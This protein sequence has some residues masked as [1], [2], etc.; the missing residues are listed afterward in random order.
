M[1]FFLGGDISVGRRHRASKVDEQG[2]CRVFGGRCPG[3]VLAEREDDRLAI[4][5]QCR[6]AESDVRL[7]PETQ[8]TLRQVNEL[9][10]HPVRETVISPG[11]EVRTRRLAA[12]DAANHPSAAT[13]RVLEQIEIGEDFLGID[14][15]VP[16]F[17]PS[18][19]PL[20]TYLPKAPAVR[21]LL[22]DPA[23]IA[24]AA[25]DELEAAE[26]RHE[27]RLRDGRLAFPPDAHYV[28]RDELDTLLSEVEPR[29]AVAYH[30]F[31]DYDTTAGLYEGIRS[32]YDGPLSLSV[33]YMVWNITKDDI[34]VRL[35]AFDEDVWPPPAT[36]K[37]Q[38]PDP[39][40]RIP[41]SAEISGGRLDVKDVIQP[42]YDEINKKYGLNEKQE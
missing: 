23:A 19:V 34:R 21:W 22:I 42:T 35:T 29:M 33:D 17:H 26:S 14:S 16:A 24:R 18:L 5:R 15:L 27:D 12:A 2:S 7:D 6:P 13:R 41:Y 30:F 37:P 38:L 25:Q 32:T 39:N 9:Y 10:V 4:I 28:S 40:E 8:R 36:E 3:G 11:A 1:L 20:W 31:K